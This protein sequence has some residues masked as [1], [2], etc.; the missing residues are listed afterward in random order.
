MKAGRHL[1]LI[2]KS[3]KKLKSVGSRRQMPLRIEGRGENKRKHQMSDCFWFQS[4]GGGGGKAP[5]K[6]EAGLNE[7]LPLFLESCNKNDGLGVP[8][9]GSHTLKT[10]AIYTTSHSLQMKEPILG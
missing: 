3:A 8:P 4:Q 6:M 5:S 10:R 9:T 2:S 1:S 7:E